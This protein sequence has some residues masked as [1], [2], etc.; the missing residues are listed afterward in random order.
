MSKQ[1]HPRAFGAVD[2]LQNLI[3]HA[4]MHNL[5]NDGEM[6]LETAR[7]MLRSIL[8]AELEAD[9]TIEIPHRNWRTVDKDGYVEVLPWADAKQHDEGDECWCHPIVE[10]REGSRP[11]ITHNAYDLREH[12]ERLAA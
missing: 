5:V 9:P 2:T 3:E 10:K 11:L 8:I 7:H 1:L 4:E 12:V 6:I